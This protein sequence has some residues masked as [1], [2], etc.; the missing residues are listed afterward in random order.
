VPEPPLGGGTEVGEPVK[1]NGGSGGGHDAG[2]GGGGDGGPSGP[3]SGGIGGGGLGSG[4][5]G[6][7]KLRLAA[8][9]AE[10]DGF[11]VRGPSGR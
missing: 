5:G 8:P 10:T 9:V 1:G 7:G 2:S 6:I 4:S 3:G 11:G